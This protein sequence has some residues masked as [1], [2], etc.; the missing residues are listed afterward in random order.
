MGRIRNLQLAGSLLNFMYLPVCYLCCERGINVIICMQLGFG[1]EILLFFMSYF[2]LKKVMSFPFWHFLGRVV[3]P[4]LLVG[5]ITLCAVYCARIILKDESFTRLILSTVTSFVIFSISAYFIGIDD[6]ERKI[7]RAASVS[8]TH[9][10][11]H[12]T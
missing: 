4:M 3:M 9:L 1:L 7:V 5:I 8:Y 11:A 12:E 6:S 2:Y 10:R